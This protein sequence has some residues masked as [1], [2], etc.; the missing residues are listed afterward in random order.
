MASR[1]PGPNERLVGL[2]MHGGH[3][4][5]DGVPGLGAAMVVASDGLR[6]NLSVEPPVEPWGR[7]F[8]AKPCRLLWAD[9]GDFTRGIDPRKI[10]K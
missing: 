6:T 5:T 8:G 4:V 2:G 1:A 9:L 3:S 7:S 10:K